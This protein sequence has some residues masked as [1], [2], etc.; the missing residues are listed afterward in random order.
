MKCAYVNKRMR[1]IS[2][3]VYVMIERTHVSFGTWEIKTTRRIST[4][5]PKTLH[6]VRIGQVSKKDAMA[7]SGST[8]LAWSGKAKTF[9]K[10]GDSSNNTS[11][12]CSGDLSN[13]GQKQ[14]S[15]VT[16]SFGWVR[17]AATC[18]IPGPT[19]PK[20]TEVSLTLVLRDSS[21]MWTHDQL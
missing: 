4:G 6:G 18:T 15:A 11:T 10:N 21:N 12:W 2:V 1:M 17:K 20:K 3:C 16:Y 19:Y 9:T 8:P 7:L 5:N 13:P 14:K